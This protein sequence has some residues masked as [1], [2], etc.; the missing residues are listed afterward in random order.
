MHSMA[1]QSKMRSFCLK[2]V[3]SNTQALSFFVSYRY[4]HVW[5]WKCV[6]PKCCWHWHSKVISCGFQVKSNTFSIF[7]PFEGIKNERNDLRLQRQ[8]Y[9]RINC[10]QSWCVGMKYKERNSMCALDVSLSNQIFASLRIACTRFRRAIAVLLFVS[11]SLSCFFRSPST[12]PFLVLS[13]NYMQKKISS[14]I[15]FGRS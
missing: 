8:W 13:A 14:H 5:D 1:N 15:S 10:K 7:R 9:N 11:L 12:S 6:K 4:T 2:L 3:K